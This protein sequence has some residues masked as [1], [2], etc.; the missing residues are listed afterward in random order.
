MDLIVV[1]FRHPETNEQR[2]QHL[3]NMMC[4]VRGWGELPVLWKL[5]AELLAAIGTFYKVQEP[6]HMLALSFLDTPLDRTSNQPHLICE[7][8]TYPIFPNMGISPD[9]LE[10]MTFGKDAVT[11]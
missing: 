10:S 9:H 4:M 7:E 2:I 3:W 5:S 6:D 11:L 1:S 8:R